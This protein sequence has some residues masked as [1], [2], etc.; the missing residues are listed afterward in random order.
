VVER[1]KRG[2]ILGHESESEDLVEA[3]LGTPF[4]HQDVKFWQA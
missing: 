4:D 1:R 3:S 2:H